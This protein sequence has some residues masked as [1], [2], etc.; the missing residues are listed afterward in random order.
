MQ[1]YRHV[2]AVPNTDIPAI[3]QTMPPTKLV[4]GP[5]VPIYS[6]I[7]NDLLRLAAHIDGQTAVPE[8]ESPSRLSAQS[9]SAIVVNWWDSRPLTTLTTEKLR[10]WLDDSVPSVDEKNETEIA[11]LAKI[12]DALIFDVDRGIALAALDAR[13]PVFVLYSNYFRVRPV[14]HLRH[15]ADRLEAKNLDDEHYDY[16]NSCL[17]KLLGFSARELSALGAA[18]DPDQHQT[19]ELETYR[20]RLDKRTYQL[21]AASVRLTDENSQRL[22]AK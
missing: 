20:E 10:A 1:R 19:A 7:K 16:G 3:L 6:E 8:G 12:Q 14:I 4:G 5:T 18:A 13:K 22:E 2:S 11:R 9:L 17:L 21:N 15:L